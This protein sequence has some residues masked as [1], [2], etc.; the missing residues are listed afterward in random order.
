MCRCLRV[1]R[2]PRPARVRPRSPPPTVVPPFGGAGLRPA[3]VRPHQT[4]TRPRRTA[5]GTRE[6]AGRPA[7][8][9]RTRAVDRLRAG[10]FQAPNSHATAGHATN[11]RGVHR[12]VMRG[13]AAGCSRRRPGVGCGWAADP[14]PPSC[15]HGHRPCDRRRPLPRPRCHGRPVPGP[16][17]RPTGRG[18]PGR[19]GRRLACPR[20]R[21]RPGGGRQAAG[22]PLPGRLH[23]PVPQ[24]GPHYRSTPATPA[25]RPC[26][27]SANCPTA[28]RSWP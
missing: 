26:T 1:R 11:G 21:P 24:R 27:T 22:R 4:A 28:A 19:H 16:R 7:G 14:P 2:R 5:I 9:R 6:G 23:R 18:R 10:G 13:P 8:V 17:V 15:P 3:G 12:T 25:S 20:P